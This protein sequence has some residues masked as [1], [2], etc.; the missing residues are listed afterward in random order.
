MS[1]DDVNTALKAQ[2]L[3]E[4]LPYIRRF[5]DKTRLTPEK[6]VLDI[7][8]HVGI[9]SLWI[10]RQQPACHVTAVEASA[11]NFEYL[12]RNLRHLDNVHTLHRAIGGHPGKF[13]AQA[14]TDRTIDTYVVEAKYDDE[15]A[16][17]A[18]LV[19]D[20]VDRSHR[21]AFMKMDVEGAEYDVFDT[22]E[23]ATLARLER[24]AMEYHDNLK[25]GT[26]DLLKRRL[27]RTHRVRVIPDEMTGHGRLFA[28][29]HTL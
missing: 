21:I 10:A 9:F 11:E 29:L 24:I 27:R 7:G 17:D 6:R 1:V 15:N 20:L 18:I 4:A 14:A 5:H 28:E 2:I 22:I 25:P 8:A 12:E 19:R 16:V 13:K 26:L 3:A 23:E